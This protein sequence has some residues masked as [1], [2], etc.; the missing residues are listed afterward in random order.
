M[1]KGH[2]LNI[3]TVCS[4]SVRL[5]VRSCF[6]Y[7]ITSSNCTAWQSKWGVWW[8]RCPTQCPLSFNFIPG[9]EEWWR[10]VWWRQ[11]Q[12]LRS[13]PLA[14]IRQLISSERGHMLRC[15]VWGGECCLMLLTPGR[16]FLRYRPPTVCS[17][18]LGDQPSP[19]CEW[20]EL[21]KPHR[22]IVS[23]SQRIISHPFEKYNVRFSFSPCF[24]SYSPSP[25]LNVL[26]LPF[27]SFSCCCFF[28][29]AE[30]RSRRRKRIR[31]GRGEEA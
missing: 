31:E 16:R 6:L 15:N 11:P 14:L 10:R 2:F 30:S 17:F 9:G 22:I 5:M 3:Y 27:F 25:P 18:V 13:L 24:F 8:S 20:S 21:I 4:V 29:L 26:P 23:K 19:R 12:A 28:I 7:Q 1:F